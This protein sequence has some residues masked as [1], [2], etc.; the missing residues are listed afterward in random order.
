MD[1][2]PYSLADRPRCLAVFDSNTPQ[3]FDPSERSL[4]ETYLDRDDLSY[5]VMDHDGDIVGCG[6][7][8]IGEDG[9]MANLVW[10]MVRRD[11]HKQGLGRFLL[12]FRLREITKANGVQMVRVGTSQHAAAFFEK[13]GF[14]AAS[15]QK[16]GYGPGIDRIEMLKKLAVCP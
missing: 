8:Y 14:K 2:R 9:L 10:G 12:M 5:F 1:I 16:D 3:F 15:V 4:F 7:Y 11:L 13:Q 6:G